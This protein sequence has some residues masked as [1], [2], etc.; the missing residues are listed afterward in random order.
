MRR[1]LVLWLAAGL[2]GVLLL[3][4]YAVEGTFWS[5]TWVASDDPRDA[6][7]LFQVLSHGR[8]WLLPIVLAFLPPLLGTE[9]TAR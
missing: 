2:V 6:S 3:P 4:W 9:P 8:V 1:P 7:A 5:F